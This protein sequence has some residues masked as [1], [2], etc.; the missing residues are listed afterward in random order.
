MTGP[1]KG[2]TIIEFS[3]IGPGPFCGMV[4]ADLGAEVI[5]IDSYLFLSLRHPNQLIPSRKKVL[6]Q[7]LK[8]L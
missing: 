4:L 3:G 7:F 8:I 1:L 6:D 5:K 2:T